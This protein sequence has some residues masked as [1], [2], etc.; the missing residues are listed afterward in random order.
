MDEDIS[1]EELAN[2]L[3]DLAPQFAEETLVV[4]D[5]ELQKIVK[6]ITPNIKGIE[7]TLK[8]GIAF[9]ASSFAAVF[10]PL[11]NILTRPIFD[12]RKTLSNSISNL[13][14]KITQP[15][16]DVRNFLNKPIFNVKDT[17][18]VSLVIFAPFY[19][20]QSLML[21]R[22]LKRLSV[23][24]ANYSDLRQKKKKKKPREKIL[25]GLSSNT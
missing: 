10:K 19:T 5:T 11:V 6:G 23:V 13:T 22:H 18:R 4:K 24:Y 17:L 9:K 12:I 1:P 8:E 16:K 20:S 14:D 2:A 15:F 7:S 25:Q 3:S 21:E